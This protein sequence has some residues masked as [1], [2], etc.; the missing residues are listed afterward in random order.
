MK[1]QQKNTNDSNNSNNKDF[2]NYHDSIKFHD[3]KLDEP[4]KIYHSPGMIHSAFDYRL[5]P[6]GS[7]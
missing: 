7:Y 6:Q 2:N 1:E 4:F 3:K 5:L